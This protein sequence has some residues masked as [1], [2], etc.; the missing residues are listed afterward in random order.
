MLKNVFIVFSLFVFSTA[1]HAQKNA[2]KGD[3][4]YFVTN[5]PVFKLGYEHRKD[6]LSSFAYG[7]NFEYGRYIVN[8]KSVT[9]STLDD[10]QMKGVGVMPQ[11]RYYWSHKTAN[12]YF[13]PFVEGFVL[14]KSVKEI[15]MRNVSV[16]H[17]GYDVSNVFSNTRKGNTYNY[18]LALG[19]RTGRP[20]GI[21]HFEVLVGYG[22][23]YNSLTSDETVIQYSSQDIFTKDDLIRME[24]NLVATF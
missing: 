4:S 12:P 8:T 3:F 7:I 2:I 10:Y 1:L 14:L 21:L 6:S 13:G 18:G 24:L 19:Y 5:L 15:S 23:G 20:A 16:S 17:N 9:T 11:A 22:F